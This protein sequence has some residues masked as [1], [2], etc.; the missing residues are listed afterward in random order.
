M[1]SNV[2]IQQ[3]Q[4][5]HTQRRQTAHGEERRNKKKQKKTQEVDGTSTQ[6]QRNTTQHSTQYIVAETN[7]AQRRATER[8][9]GQRI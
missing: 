8:E 2:N 7:V 1:N 4:H 5:T 6:Q 9:V 3:P